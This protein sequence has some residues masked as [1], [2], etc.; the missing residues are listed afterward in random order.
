MAQRAAHVRGSHSSL[1]ALE[2]VAADLAALRGGGASGAQQAAQPASV[3][4]ADAHVH[5]PRSAAASAWHP[6]VDI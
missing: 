2:R 4:R 6:P 5:T 1:V 3:R